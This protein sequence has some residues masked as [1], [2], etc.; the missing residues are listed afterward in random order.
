M[1]KYVLA[2]LALFIPASL[3]QPAGANSASVKD[4][5]RSGQYIILIRHALAPGMGD[6]DAFKIGDCSTQRN[7]SREGREQARRIGQ[8]LRTMGVKN[9]LVYTSQWCRCME[10][11]TLMRAGK[12]TELPAL[13][14]FFGKPEAGEA[15]M[16]A[17]RDWL[18]KQS[19]R[20]PLVLVTHQVNITAFTDV[21]PE[22]GEAVVMRRGKDGSLTLA[23][24]IK[25][26][27][28]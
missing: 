12:I 16:Q 15:Q 5:I 23:G 22:S 9:G 27:A 14:S 7:L 11:A 19:F 4:T 20:R 18:A 28:P 25:T 26:E 8:R 1:I 6:P 17:L 2:V 24:T 21:F 13:N 10:T 3:V